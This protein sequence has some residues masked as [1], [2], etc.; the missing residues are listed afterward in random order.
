MLLQQVSPQSKTLLSIESILNK[1]AGYSS[2]NMQK[3]KTRE[4][5]P[6]LRALLLA[7]LR[8]HPFSCWLITQYSSEKHVSM[9][10]YML[11]QILL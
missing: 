6:D 3:G 10:I 8:Y 7:S 2:S 4:G 5:N 1:Y 11:S 9:I